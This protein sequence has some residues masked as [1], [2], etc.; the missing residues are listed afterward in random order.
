MNGREAY[1]P[2]ANNS[3]NKKR[4]RTEKTGDTLGFKKT[5][6]HFLHNNIKDVITD[7]GF[8]VRFTT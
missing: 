1:K 4:M 7:T 5:V 6:L 2:E 3:M 8:C